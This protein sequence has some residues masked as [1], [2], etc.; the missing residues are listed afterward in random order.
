VIVTHKP[1]IMMMNQEFST[2][3]ISTVSAVEREM[4][5]INDIINASAKE[6]IEESKLRD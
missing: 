5:A 6:E 4:N 3:I 1:S 2:S